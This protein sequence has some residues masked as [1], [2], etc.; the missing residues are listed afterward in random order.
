MALLFAAKFDHPEDWLSALKTELPGMEIRLWPKIGD[1]TEIDYALTWKPEPGL[2][3]SLP[4]LKAILSLGAG[5]DGILAD[6][7]V[8]RHV[9]LVRLVDHG[10]TEGM[11]EFVVWRVLEWHRQAEI[12]RSQQR[13][14]LW[15]PRRQALARERK[16]GV[17]GLGELGRAA[18]HAL[19]ALNFDVAGWSRSAKS[20]D[21]IT[22]FQGGGQGLDHFLA[23]SEVLI[24]LLPLTPDTAGILGGRTFARLP[25][26]AYLINAARGGHLV[27]PDLLAALGSGQISGAALDVFAREPLP[28]DHPFWRDPRIS[29]TPHVA[30][31]THARTAA[32]SIAASI[33]RAEAGEA[34]DY[35]VD[36]ETG[37]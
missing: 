1:R 9:P 20:I 27:E 34:L 21:G 5:V 36:L 10:L 35:V 22:C 13:K 8:P 2:L 18:A 26:G 30:S 7:S 28:G 12:Y 19:A 4:N 14:S 32:K 24:C 31:D 17:M 23:R 6:P 16:I 33:R 11:V 29:I 25:R 15:Q 3:A 37:Y